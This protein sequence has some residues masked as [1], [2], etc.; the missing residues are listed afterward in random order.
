MPKTF[1]TLAALLDHGYDAVID[2]R[3]PAE[4]AEDHLPGAI[5]L[6]VLSDTERAKVGTI[7]KQVSAFDARKVGAALVSRNAADH[8][9]GPL[10][11]FDGGWRPLVYCWRGGQRSGSFTS[12]LQQI[13]WRADVIAGGYQTY[14]RLVHGAMYD[15]PLP[16]RMVLLDGNTGTA[17]TDILARLAAFDVQIVDLEGLAGH[18]GS[19]LGDIPEGQPS[20]KQF[21]SLLASAFARLDPHKITVVEAES[22]KI[23]KRVIPPTV[24]AQMIAAPRIQI[25]ASLAAR[26]GWLVAAYAEVISDRQRLRGQLDF[27]RRHRGHETVNRWVALLE[28]GDHIGLAAALMADHYDP[29]YAK[30]RANHRHDVIATLHAETLDREGRAAMTEQIKQILDRL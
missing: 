22:S 21:E 25:D 16:H 7:Y 29:A 13:G 17:K 18:R 12:I 15:V 27:L 23:G 8:I 19:L 6:P 4:F 3:S 14:R 2:V 30:S 9:A 5:N 10:K 20:Q 11:G 28:S 24:W 26:A 1:D